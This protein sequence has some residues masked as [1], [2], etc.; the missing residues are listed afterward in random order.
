MILRINT[1][2][3]QQKEMGYKGKFMMRAMYVLWY[4]KGTFRAEA[5]FNSEKPK[6]VALSIIELYLCEGIRQVVRSVR[7][8]L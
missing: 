1:L 4:A 7:K 2:G 8:F 5:T 3:H 6:P